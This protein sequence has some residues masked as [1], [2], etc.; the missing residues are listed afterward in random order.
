MNLA[1]LPR[2]YQEDLRRCTFPAPMTLRLA[3][4]FTIEELAEIYNQARSDYIVPM[5]MNA[6]RL[7]EYIRNY[8][9]ALE[10]SV[11]AMDGEQV[12][13]LSMLGVR[14]QHTWITRLGV[15]PLQ[16]RRGTGELLMGHHI[17]RSRKLNVKY[18]TLDV[19]K[20]NTPAHRLFTKLGFQECREL[21]ILRRPPGPPKVEVPQ[22]Q[23]HMLEFDEAVALLQQRKSVPSWLDETPSM[24]NAGNLHALEVEL[25]DGARGW[26][27]YQRTIFQLGRLVLQT[28]AGNPR[29]VARALA[30]AL[31]TQNPVQD[32]KTEN[33][34]LLDP[35]LPG[36]QDMGYIESFRRIEL[37]LTFKDG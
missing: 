4:E 27:V 12:L 20:N 6:A 31:H 32:T 14:P 18:I 25:A 22:Y 29:E 3:T 26:V 35:H 9:V 5:P 11:V 37:H 7:Q 17:E 33:F 24:V 21:L 19:I 23:A 28:E 10:H 13:G 1:D 30:H 16:R 8:D 15:L 34:P 2:P 36:L